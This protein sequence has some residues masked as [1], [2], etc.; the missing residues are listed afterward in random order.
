MDAYV[1]G[2][3]IS[4][5]LENAAILMAAKN[6]KYT[7]ETQ[8]LNGRAIRMVHAVSISSISASRYSINRGVG[9]F[10]LLGDGNYLF[11]YDVRLAVEVFDLTEAKK[12]PFFRAFASSIDSSASV[13]ATGF[14]PGLL[15]RF[16]DR[17]DV[18]LE[19]VREVSVQVITALNY[20]R[21]QGSGQLSVDDHTIDYKILETSVMPE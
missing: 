12:E 13:L 2:K 14:P 1:L 9:F 20:F 4:S 17:R 6:S 5:Y 3:D 21:I 11:V 8:K 19:G 7:R 16:C 10:I 15:Q 18:H